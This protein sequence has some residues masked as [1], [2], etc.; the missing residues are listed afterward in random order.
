MNNPELIGTWIGWEP[1]AFDGR[2]AAFAG[3][4]GYDATGR[5]LP[6]WHHS[7]DDAAVEPLTGYGTPGKGDW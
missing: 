2:D 1:N 5:F 4:S 3:T 7:G 6:Y